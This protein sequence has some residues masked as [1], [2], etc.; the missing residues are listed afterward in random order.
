MEWTIGD[1]HEGVEILPTSGTKSE[2][3]SIMETAQMG[4]VLTSLAAALPRTCLH[5][6]PIVLHL[7]LVLPAQYGQ[8]SE[9]QVDKVIVP[10]RWI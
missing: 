3:S 6:L 9:T 1:R 7:A 4:G 5:V 2:L 8:K 10:N